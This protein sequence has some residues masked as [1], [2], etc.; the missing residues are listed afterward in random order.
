MRV[1]QRPIP[2]G[3]D[4]L[5]LQTSL[6]TSSNL[7]LPKPS[8][9]ATVAAIADE[10]KTIFT[11]TDALTSLPGFMGDVVNSNM[12]AVMGM[13]MSPAVAVVQPS[14]SAVWGKITQELLQFTGAIAQ[15]V[16]M[17]ENKV[18]Y[19]TQHKLLKDLQG[20]VE[21]FW[22]GVKN[23]KQDPGPLCQ[24]PY[25][26][27]TI[28]EQFASRSEMYRESVRLVCLTFPKCVEQQGL[29]Y[30]SSMV[31]AF[32]NAKMCTSLGA[33]KES[34]QGISVQRVTQINTVAAD[35]ANDMNEVR[36]K[37]IGNT[38]DDKGSVSI[39]NATTSIGSETS[40]GD[41]HK[42]A[43]KAN[44]N[45]DWLNMRVVSWSSDDEI[46]GEDECG[47]KFRFSAA[48]DV[49]QGMRVEKAQ[50]LIVLWENTT[51]PSAIEITSIGLPFA[52]RLRELEAKYNAYPANE[53]FGFAVLPQIDVRAEN[54]R[55]PPGEPSFP[56]RS[57][58]VPACSWSRYTA[59]RTIPP[60]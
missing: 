49:N 59:S 23:M 47:T 57:R 54:G 11:E 16:D 27:E 26:P 37:L 58:D 28:F 50:R 32:R 39:A 45:Y 33:S 38:A 3:A 8:A 34:R 43:V 60:Q 40:D 20:Q 48:K 13:V 9:D 12:L 24:S 36:R 15:Y 21:Y 1:R 46:Y 10:A 53:K 17:T 52:D 35:F 30:L 18:R 56:A 31:L 44:E 41:R 5:R 22:M 19:E 51:S 29:E 42:A 25:P 4:S 6:S 14:F 2:T 55:A 7:T